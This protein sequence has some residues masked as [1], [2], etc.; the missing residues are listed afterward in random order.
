MQRNNTST[1]YLKTK[2]ICKK[3][4]SIP[5]KLIYIAQYN[6]KIF[7]LQKKIGTGTYF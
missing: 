4:K 1:I 6:F 5:Y 2:A 3:K 7:S